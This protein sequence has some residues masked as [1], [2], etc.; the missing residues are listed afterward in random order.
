VS[1]EAALR[2][3][4]EGLDAAQSLQREAQQ[5]LEEERLALLG[6]AG[7]IANQETQLT[8]LA[9]RR[10]ELK[11]RH[12][13]ASAELESLRSQETSLDRERNDA[14]RR[15]QQSRQLTLELAERRGLEEESLH[16]LRAQFAESEVAVISLREEL[17]DRR[18]RLASLEE[19]QRHYEGFD[20]GVRAVMLRAGAEARVQGI[21]GLV[22]DVVSTSARFE[23]AVEA[24]LGS[25]A[26]N[27]LV[28]SRA[29]GVELSRYLA[30]VAEGRS[31][32]LPLPEAVGA[33]PGPLPEGLP[34]LVARAAD[35]VRTEALFRPVVE[36][37]LGG[38]VIA[39]DLEAAL[40]IR[41]AAPGWT[42][43]SLA[44]E[45]LAADRNLAGGVREGPGAGALQKK[46]EIAELAE[47]VAATEG[48][49]NEL[50]TRHYALQKQ[51]LHTEE[52]LK[53][54]QKHHHE[55][56]LVRSALEKDLHQASEQLA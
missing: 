47:G 52:V 28:E 22:A 33:A 36:L 25:R 18:S 9:P 11:E 42:V 16:R 29:V 37:L 44:R 35:E 4:Q 24:A 20:R 3:A 7:R 6:L 15:V 23:R 49:Y 27:V 2:R 12:S 54:L 56:E 31:S 50:L 45:V 38:V 14:T 21:F 40:R 48:R 43:V 55:E 5:R 1:D 13:R 30:S 34:G 8:A 53:G 19:I 17:A 26:E 46:R 10:E 41:D 51:I 39:E 32:F